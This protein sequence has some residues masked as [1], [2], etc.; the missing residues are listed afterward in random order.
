MI[1]MVFLGGILNCEF[2]SQVTTRSQIRPQK[3][4][5][6]THVDRV[7]VRMV[8]LDVRRWKRG[9]RPHTSATPRSGDRTSLARRVLKRTRYGADIPT[10]NAREMSGLIRQPCVT[11][12]FAKSQVSL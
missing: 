8:V 11:D 5:C 3:P 6:H 9:S 4:K 7:G 12:P 2:R 1:S 10:N